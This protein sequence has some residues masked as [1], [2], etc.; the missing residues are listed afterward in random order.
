MRM[1]APPGLPRGTSQARDG[2]STG[3]GMGQATGI[4][5]A[6]VAQVVEEF[7]VF[8]VFVADNMVVGCSTVNCSG[9]PR[10]FPTELP[11]ERLL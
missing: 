2:R 11:A 3:A 4:L 7:E 5:A 1:M 10:Y 6:S 8:E 9:L